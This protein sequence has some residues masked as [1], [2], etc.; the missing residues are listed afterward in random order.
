MHNIIINLKKVTQGFYFSKCLFMDKA[1]SINT[2]FFCIGEGTLV[3]AF[4]SIM[5]K[6]LNALT[7]MIPAQ[8]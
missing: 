3:S 5:A 6:G 1:P 4:P 7:Q 8:Q 2:M